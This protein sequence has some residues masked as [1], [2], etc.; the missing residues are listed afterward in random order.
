MNK[1]ITT[2]LAFALTTVAWAQ[3]EKRPFKGYFHND[4]Y[5]VFLRV[6]LYDNDIAVPNHDIFGP[7]PGYFAKD[8][9]NFYWLITSAKLKSAHKAELSLINDYG[10]EDLTATL[11]VKND[12]VV[13]LRQEGGSPLKVPNKGKWQKMPTEMTLK[14]K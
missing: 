5:G 7:L 9:N 6:N 3:D 12:S 11:T 1:V 8:R 2:L 10:S 13:V 4:E 14:R